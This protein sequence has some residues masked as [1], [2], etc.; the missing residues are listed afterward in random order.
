ML[1]LSKLQPGLSCKVQL[2]IVV[3]V[4]VELVLGEPFH[5]H[6][7]LLTLVVLPPTALILVGLPALISSLASLPP[8]PLAALQV[9]HSGEQDPLDLPQLLV[10]HRRAAA[11]RERPINAEGMFKP[12]PRRAFAGM[13][14]G[15]RTG[16]LTLLAFRRRVAPTLARGLPIRSASAQLATATAMARARLLRHANAKMK[17]ALPALS[18]LPRTAA[19]RP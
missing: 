1:H 12:E 4:G 7:L 15:G 8:R 13:G 3:G 6:A 16:G 9:L 19:S 5:Q 14:A 18:R 11:Q 10:V 17:I 2:L